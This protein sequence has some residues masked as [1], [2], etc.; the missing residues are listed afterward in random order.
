MK[1]NGGQALIKSL[2]MEGVEV[3]LRPARRCHPAGVRPDHRLADPPHPR[4]PRAGRRPHGRGLR[5][6]HG[7]ARRGHGDQRAGRHQHRH[8]AGRRLHGLDPDGRASPA[9][10]RRRS[11]G[12][13]AFQ[14]SDITGITQSVTKHN[15][16][17][18]ERGRHPH[19]H[20]RGVPHR[21]HRPARPGARRHPQ[22]HRRPDE[23]G[24]AMD[25]YWPSDDDVAA[26]LP[27]YQPHHA[28]PPR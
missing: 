17:V 7:P 13:D 22:G 5:P 2:E 21:H 8:A 25:W 3:D 19:R 20:P 18:T 23:P 27:G 10:S 24:S 28:G 15:F 9:R 11:I 4:A 26:E 12:T 14:E 6:R 1:L 16:L